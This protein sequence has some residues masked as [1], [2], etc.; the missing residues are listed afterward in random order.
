V[1]PATFSAGTSF[2]GITLTKVSGDAQSGPVNAQLPVALVV[3]LRNAG[4]VGI[5]GAWV[6]WFVA[7]GNGTATPD[8]SLTD[9]AGQAE[10]RWTMPATSGPMTLTADV[11]GQAAVT[12]TALAQSGTAAS[13]ALVSGDA[14]TAEVGAPLAAPLVVVVRDA[15][16]NP[17]VGDSV[18]WTVTAGGGTFAAARTATDVNGE[19]RATWTLGLE[20]NVAHGAS[21]SIGTLPAVSFTATATLPATLLMTKSAGDNQAG[22][23][24]TTLPDSLE[25]ALRLA[26]GRAVKGVRVTW[27]ASHGGTVAA[28]ATSTS[29]AGRVRARWTLGLTNGEQRAVARWH[30][31]QNAPVDS[32]TF[33]AAAQA[34]SSSSITISGGNGQTGDV[35]AQ[36]AE[37]LAVTVRDALGNPVS[38]TVVNWNVSGGGGTVSALSTVT[39]A[40]GIARV[41]WTLG[42]KADVTHT[43]TAAMSG[44]TPVQFTAAPR[45]PASLVFV[46]SGGDA[47]TAT[48]GTALADSL[49]VTARLSDGR[50][51]EGVRVTWA[52]S[53]GGQ[54]APRAARTAADGRLR[55][56][57]T[58]GVTQGAQTVVARWL[59]S[60]DAVVDSVT[61]TGTATAPPGSR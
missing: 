17:A 13:I 24:G 19:A 50:A 8:S 26:D 56:R 39:N 3:V 32:V 37:S 49:E 48:A 10:V 14:Q 21:A 43:A 58:L 57:W 46:K 30:N 34:G 53:H 35:G 25:V 22:T 38:G 31:A 54:V 15:A 12:F 23:V 40:S 45:L 36:L 28:G 7:P 41:A 9:G 61:F 4:N 44:V 11:A 20:A 18:T 55:A 47:Q 2:N 27:S 16:G 51:V 42:L 1:A 52:A 6:R 60:Q 59:N 29:D 33:T 5:A